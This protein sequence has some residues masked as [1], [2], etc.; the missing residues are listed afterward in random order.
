MTV[1]VWRAPDSVRTASVCVRVA[2]SEP[3][4]SPHYHH[5]R[6]PPLPPPARVILDSDFGL[7]GQGFFGLG[8]QGW[9]GLGGLG[10]VAR[11]RCPSTQHP[12][13]P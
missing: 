9:S 11:V 7:A 10:V 12:I 13:S 1:W 8:G 4:A 2:Q 3:D 5:P 6:P